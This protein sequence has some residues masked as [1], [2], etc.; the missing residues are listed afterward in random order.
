MLNPIQVG[1]A[2]IAIARSVVTHP[3]TCFT[4]T[5]MFA[6]VRFLNE[7]AKEPYEVPVDDIKD[8][9]PADENDFDGG[10][11]YSAFWKDDE[12][13]ENTGQY[14]AQVL[15]L[16]A[17]RE[18]LRLKRASRRVAKPLIHP[19]DIEVEEDD[20]LTDEGRAKQPSKQG[21]KSRLAAAQL[22]AKNEAYKGILEKHQ[23][24]AKRKNNDISSSQISRKRR[25]VSASE[26]DSSSDELTS[27]SELK[28]A[29]LEA[30]HWR[31]R[32]DEVVK[33]NH[34]L[35]DIIRRMQSSVSA[36]LDTIVQA[37]EAQKENHP[38]GHNHPG[39]F[40]EN[41]WEEEEEPSVRPAAAL[42]AS[43]GP[44]AQEVRLP[45]LTAAEAGTSH[46]CPR[47]VQSTPAPAAP[48]AVHNALARSG[49]A[50]AAPVDEPRATVDPQVA[51]HVP[52]RDIG[53]GRYHVKAGLIIGIRQAEK[54]FANKKPALVAKDMAQAIWGREGLAERTYGGKLAPKDLKKDGAVARKQLSP[55]K[56]AAIIETVTRWGAQTGLPVK[57][58][59]HNIGTILSQKIQDLRKS[60]KK[61]L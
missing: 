16:A 18:G 27:A 14:P 22:A 60:F 55:E 26:S 6:L 47:E 29:R 3:K 13:P 15:L 40:P 43:S 7:Y 45:A 48:T 5:K 41:H 37:L 8:F 21:S 49:A 50:T 31:R 12:V 30:K 39:P 54:V 1:A 52:F 57:D 23:A 53:G 34:G 59:V 56:V 44:S 42:C 10:K 11:V 19:S 36:K 58:T 2:A 28:Q 25:H 46:A 38:P 17:S 61:K 4:T 24:Q 9:H 33:E 20:G 32:F 35:Q 51:G